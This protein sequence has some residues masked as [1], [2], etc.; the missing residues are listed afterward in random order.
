[1]ETFVFGLEIHSLALPFMVE[2]PFDFSLHCFK[3]E[4]KNK[5]RVSNGV[6]KQGTTLFWAS[7]ELEWRRRKCYT[8]SLQFSQTFF[9]DLWYSKEHR[10]EF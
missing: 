8:K 2:L 6:S 1:M 7:S 5:D 4:Q 9:I 3:E 10:D